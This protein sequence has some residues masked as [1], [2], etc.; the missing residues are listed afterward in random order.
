MKNLE[1]WLMVLFVIALYGST[2][3]NQ[4]SMSDHVE[5]KKIGFIAQ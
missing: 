3:F 1:T 5:I 2:Y 4:W